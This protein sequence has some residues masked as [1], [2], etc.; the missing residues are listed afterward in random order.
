MDV[1]TARDYAQINAKVRALKSSMLTV[2]DY[3]KLVQATNIDDVI[4]LLSATPYAEKIAEVELRPP[5]DLVQ[6]DKFL[7]EELL[8]AFDLVINSSSGKAKDYLKLYREKFYYDNLKLIITAVINKT[9]KQT[10]MQ[11]LLSPSPREMEE[12]GVL[13]DS[14]TVYQA[15]DQIRNRKAKEALTAAL[16]QFESLNIPLVLENALDGKIYGELWAN[17]KKL[18]RSDRKY[19]KTII[20][21]KIDLI[22]ILTIL[23]GKSLQLR[24]EIIEQLILPVFYKSEQTIRE[25]IGAPNIEGVLNILSVSEFRY[26]AY[27]AKEVYEETG[28]LFE[29]EHAFNEYLTQLIYSQ[30]IGFPF[31]IGVPIAYLELKSQEIRNIK[32]IIVGKVEAIEPSKIRDLLT[33]F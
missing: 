25:C 7:S 13:L 32:I 3:E 33:I 20:G 8:T 26:L 28:S 23:R 18:S 24:P 16:P 4:R 2:G 1:L 10:V 17:I 29:I 14:Q 27:R 9:P 22:N 12:F 31:H 5:I 6:I 30:L 19:A 11:Y 15:I 21:T